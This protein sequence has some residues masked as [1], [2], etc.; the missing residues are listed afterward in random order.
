MLLLLL[1]VLEKKKKSEHLWHVLSVKPQVFKLNSGDTMAE[2]FLAS[3]K[4]SVAGRMIAW[5]AR[6]IGAQKIAPIF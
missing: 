1:H 3:S 5:Q 6:A 4:L 2:E